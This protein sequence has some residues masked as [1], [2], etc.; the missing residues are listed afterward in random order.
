MERARCVQVVKVNN[1]PNRWIQWDGLDRLLPLINWVDGQAVIFSNASSCIIHVGPATPE[2]RLAPLLRL[3]ANPNLRKVWVKPFSSSSHPYCS[4]QDANE[5]LSVVHDAQGPN[6]R[7]E[8]LSIFP[9]TT[10]HAPQLRTTLLSKIA[11]VASHLTHCTL[12]AWALSITALEVLAR[13]PLMRL[14]VQGRFATESGDLSL[15]P[16]LQLPENAFG[17]LQSLLVSYVPVEPVCQ[18]VATPRILA[19]IQAL[20][21]EVSPLDDLFIDEDEMYNRIL[22]RVIER[23]PR[24]LTLCLISSRNEDSEGYLVGAQVIEALIAKRLDVLRLYRFKLEGL[25]FSRLLPGVAEWENLCHLAIMHQD[26]TPQDLSCLSI[27]PNLSELSGN[28]SWPLGKSEALPI[29]NGFA[30]WL[31]LASQFRFGT[32]YRAIPNYE[33]VVM[34]ICK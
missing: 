20:R 24:L 10:E 34:R 5:A 19:N 3:V 6:S 29:A 7:L 25:G 17:L 23:T 1:N 32:K 31:D 14:E 21:I 30:K 8:W 33:R 2:L 12:S 18:L 16:T 11:P 28:I 4:I 22:T 15:A 27:L 26:L 9:E 13:A